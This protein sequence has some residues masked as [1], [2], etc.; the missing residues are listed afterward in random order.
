MVVAHFTALQLRSVLRH[1]ILLLSL[2]VLPGC[3]DAGSTDDVYP[4]EPIKVIVPFGAGGG[5]DS[6]A[7][8]LERGIEENGLLDQPL[9]IVNLGG[10]G[11]TIGSRRAKNAP[12]DGHTVMVLHNAILTAKHT[13]LVDYGPEAFEPVAATGFVGQ[14]VAVWDDSD[15]ETLDDL[16]DHAREHPG[17]LRWACNLGALTHFSGLQLQQSEKANGAAFN[18]VPSGGGEARFSDLKGGNVDVTGFSLEEYTRYKSEGLRGLCFLGS[19]QRRD[20]FEGFDL[21]TA[22]ELGYTEVV[23]DNL[24]YWWMP[25]GTPNDRIEKFAEVLEKAMQLP[26]VREQLEKGRIS[27]VFLDGDEM[28]RT[29]A[30]A[31]ERNAKIIVPPPPS[32]P[33]FPMIALVASVALGVVVV[34]R[35]VASRRTAGDSRPV[36]GD[37]EV[38]AS[39]DE[40]PETE[41]LNSPA[42]RRVDLAFGVALVTILYVAALSLEL[43][44]FRIVTVLFVLATGGL[45]ASRTPKSLAGVAAVAVV[46]GLG[47]HAVF[48]R[49]FEIQLP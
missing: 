25:E 6:F 40:A 15:F 37:P 32:L 27:P 26:E 44:D 33:D 11:G 49:L 46:V 30:A 35:D 41:G 2:C 1:R 48:V 18:F 43:V 20:E 4:S 22:R 9:V 13:R 10:A 28:K 29:L 31:E 12:P 36:T 34:A 7:R 21:P 23:R 3:G 45:L 47:I 16:V 14:V 24:F 38:E 39:N 19:E 5:T 17:E 8:I 42:R